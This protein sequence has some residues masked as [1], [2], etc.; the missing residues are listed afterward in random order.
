MNINKRSFHYIRIKY[1]V[2]G[3]DQRLDRSPLVDDPHN[4]LF[5]SCNV[6]KNRR[7]DKQMSSSF[8]E[9]VENINPFEKQSSLNEYPKIKNTGKY[10]SLIPT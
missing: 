5:C 8:D 2:V 1:S 6:D 7:T 4:K 3:V 10:S 9:T